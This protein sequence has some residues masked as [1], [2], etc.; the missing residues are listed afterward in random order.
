[1]LEQKTLS[2]AYP[3]SGQTLV[4]GGTLSL[5]SASS[6]P[7]SPGNLVISNG[8]VLTANASSGTPLPANNLVVGTNSTLTL[9]LNGTANGI[10]AAGSLTFQDNATNNFNYGTLTVNPTAPAINASGGISA[11]GANIYIGITALGLQPGTFTLIKYT[12]AALAMF[13][14]FI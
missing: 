8:A 1:M 10:N 14:I 3:Y 7:S 13:P 2:G 9:A 6:V 5:N 12:G 4:A 11:P